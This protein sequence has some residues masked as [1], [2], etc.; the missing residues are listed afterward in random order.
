[1]DVWVIND[2]VIYYLGTGISQR[3]NSPKGSREGN[4]NSWMITAVGQIIPE[5][6]LG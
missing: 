4:G 2:V 6:L 5:E 3:N 1:M